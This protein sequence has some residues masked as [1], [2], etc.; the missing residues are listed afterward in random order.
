MNINNTLV[1]IITPSYN[2]SRFIA[3][4]IIS[5]LNQTYRNWELL[6]TDDCS[7]DNSVDIINSYIKDD[8]RIKLFKSTQN[9]GAAAAR[10]ISIRNASGKYIAFLD[11]DDVWNP[12][13]LE[14]QLAFMRNNNYS[15]TFTA[16]D[17]MYEDGTKLNKT[18]HAPISVNYKQY[19]RNTIIGC[20][21]VIVDKEVTGDFEM[22]LKR[23]S[24][25]MALWLLIMR[26][27][28][29]AYGLNEITA[30]YRLVSNSNTAN[31]KRAAKEV[32]KVYREVEQLDVFNSVVNFL[33]YAFN[34]IKKRM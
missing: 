14:L 9:I 24:H 34:A 27:G 22:P 32:W 6:I 1:S 18:I 16:Y 11:S 3:D 21:T 7:N 33:G 28:I 8:S 12:D 17:L 31:K 23:S 26:R 10:N 30:T 20:L 25:D 4:T 5:V 29:T 15:F 13:K 19:L 2:S